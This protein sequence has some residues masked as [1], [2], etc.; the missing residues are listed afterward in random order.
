MR[1][2]YRI[3]AALLAILL[4][5]LAGCGK[6]DTPG[7]E[8]GYAK[9]DTMPDFSVPLVGGGAFTLSENLGKPVFIN[10]YATWCG[11]CVSE[12]PEIDRLCGEFGDQVA[13]VAIGLAESE[14]TAQDFADSNGYSLP[15]AYA[16]TGS[17]FEDYDIQY[18]PQTFVL[19]ADGTITA[20]F[21][22][23]TDYESFKAAIE[24]AMES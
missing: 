6:T 19:D 12:M 5:P 18:I 3:T 15:F 24:E 9:G 7:V 8:A 4:L 17:P 22:R 21:D 16:E 23:R 10:L 20:F 1:F 13:F 14:A 2:R 11:P